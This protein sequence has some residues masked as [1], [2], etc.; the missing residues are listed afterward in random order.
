[1]KEI[2]EIKNL[3][4]LWLSGVGVRDTGLKDLATLTN[5]TRLGLDNTNVTDHGLKELVTLKN[6]SKLYL[7]GTR[8]TDA[9]IEELKQA[10]RSVRSSGIE[11][12]TRAWRSPQSSKCFFTNSQADSSWNS[13]PPSKIRWRKRSGNPSFL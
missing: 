12:R 8:V 10:L 7:D 1:M 11:A 3:S 2:A 9:G 5:L 6:L 13:W 4:V